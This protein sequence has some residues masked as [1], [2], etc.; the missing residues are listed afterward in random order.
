MTASQINLVQSRGRQGAGA[1]VKSR[2]R[3]IAP[4]VTLL[5]LIAFFSV[6]SPSFTTIDNVG[7]IL[8]SVN[9]GIDMLNERARSL[10]G[11][12]DPRDLV[13]LLPR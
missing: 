6:A 2:M 12:V 9:V 13:F 8:T 4:F 7:N 5:L 10:I 11:Y 3:N 1:V